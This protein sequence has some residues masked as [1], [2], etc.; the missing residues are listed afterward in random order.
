MSFTADRLSCSARPAISPNACCSLAVCP[1]REGL[2]QPT[3]DA[4][5]LP[6]RI[7]TTRATGR[8][9]EM[10]WKN[11][12][13]RPAGRDGVI[14]RA[15]VLPA[16]RCDQARRI[17]SAR[18]QGGPGQK[19]LAIFLSTAPSLFE[20]PSPAWRMPGLPEGDVRIGLEKPLG[21]DLARAARS[22]RRSPAPSPKA[23]SFASI[24]ISQGNRPDLLALRFANILFEPI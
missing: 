22:T 5:A 6:V 24:T 16:A 19:G 12:W 15:A 14:P 23:A 3:S 8:S 7:S 10:R 4:W 17:Q 11:I 18:R 13:G 9:P 20:R 1:P 21:T 2:L